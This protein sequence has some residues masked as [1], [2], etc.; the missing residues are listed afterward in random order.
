MFSNPPC[1]VSSVFRILVPSP[2]LALFQILLNKIDLVTP[3]DIAVV[4]QRIRHINPGVKVGHLCLAD[5][6][7]RC[8]RSPSFF[9]ARAACPSLL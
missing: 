8:S 9:V 6:R 3:A 1:L 7:S 2:D 5:T 4:E